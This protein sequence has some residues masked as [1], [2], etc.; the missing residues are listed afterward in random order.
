MTRLLKYALALWAAVSFAVAIYD[1]I[2]GGFHIAVAGIRLS[3]FEAYKPFRNGL[4]CACAAFWLNDREAHNT[5][6]WDRLT[7]WAGPLALG[8]AALSVVAAIRFGIFVAGG[9]DA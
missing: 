4:A 7:S 5:A 2:P 8:A 1:I 9:S 6:C 3:S